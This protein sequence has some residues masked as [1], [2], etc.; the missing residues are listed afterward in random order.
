MTKIIRSRIHEVFSHEA[1]VEFELLARCRDISNGEKHGEINRLL[2]KYDVTYSKLGPGTNRYAVKIKGYVFKFATD[3]DGK[4]DNMKEFQMCPHLY[5]HVAMTYEISENGT[6][7]VA[8]Y[9]QPFQSFTEMC[10]YADEIR[11]I[12]S[13]LSSQYL[14]G[15]VGIDSKNYANW[16]L[17]IGTKDPVCL[18]FA[19]VYKV[20]SKLFICDKPNCSHNSILVPDTDF[21][22]L[23]CNTCK[24]IY[25]FEE[26]RSR[27]GN[28][29]VRHEIGNL[30]DTGYLMYSPSEE[31][32]LD[33]ER[34]PYI[35]NISD[36]D[37]IEGSNNNSE[38]EP[39]ML[40]RPID[41][42]E[43]PMPNTPMTVVVGVVDPRT[44]AHPSA[45]AIGDK[46]VQLVTTDRTH[47]DP[48]LNS[49][50]PVTLIKP[51][52]NGEQIETIYM[53]TQKG[54][55]KKPTTT[56]SAPIIDT[57]DDHV[58]DMDKINNIDVT[59]PKLHV[60]VERGI[61]PH[62]INTQVIAEPVKI[63]AEVSEPVDEVK[64]E[65]IPE[66]PADEM[67]SDIEEVA[68]ADE[69][70]PTV[71]DNGP[72][73]I[74]VRDYKFTKGFMSG[75]GAHLAVGRITDKIT[76][77]INM[78][79]L[80][81]EVSSHIKTKVF[82]GDFGTIVNKSLFNTITRFC[83]MTSTRELGDD[84]VHRTR[85]YLGDDVEDLKYKP[86]LIFM[87][88]AFNTAEIYQ[89][90]DRAL[91]NEFRKRYHNCCGLQPDALNGFGKVIKSKC[92][93]DDTGVQIITD[94]I[95]KK[96]GAPKDD[97]T[98]APQPQVAETEP[99]EVSIPEPI[100]E[101]K[102]PII[103]VDSIAHHMPIE[104]EIPQDPEEDDEE[105]E[106]IDDGEV[107]EQYASEDEVI[108]EMIQSLK[109]AQ[110]DDDDDSM[111]EISLADIMGDDIDD[112]QD[113]LAAALG[114]I[115]GDEHED[116]LWDMAGMIM[117]KMAQ[118]A[119]EYP[120]YVERAVMVVVQDVE[121]DI[122]PII[123]ITHFDQVKCALNTMTINPDYTSGEKG[124]NNARAPMFCTANNEWDWLNVV[125]PYRA[126]TTTA[127]H[128]TTLL[129][130][131]ND[132]CDYEDENGINY[133]MAVIDRL[134][135]G[136]IVMGLYPVSMSFVDIHDN[137]R[138]IEDEH[139][140]TW[141]KNKINMEIGTTSMSYRD[142]VLHDIES[143]INTTEEEIYQEFIYNDDSDDD[144]DDDDED[145]INMRSLV[146]KGY[147]NI[148]EGDDDQMEMNQEQVNSNTQNDVATMEEKEQAAIHALNHDTPD[149]AADT[150]LDAI[151]EDVDEVGDEREQEPEIAP[152]VPVE[153]NNDPIPVHHQ[154]SYEPE[155]DDLENLVIPRYRK[156]DRMRGMEM[157]R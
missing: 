142:R 121:P 33:E 147:E 20:S 145:P 30:A 15:D 12:L 71:E 82:K 79:Q 67:V 113:R 74:N 112:F 39:E 115:S 48:M 11:K 72:K 51:Q 99:E 149:V 111:I 131:F 114:C 26:I 5:P 85:W 1:C 55:P 95:M 128:V 140:I 69:P 154:V 107:D 133:R 35:S 57:A 13:D 139:E 58:V 56:I 24:A 86:T 98:E 63:P 125:E 37:N 94:L 155:D 153:R 8:E 32:E 78:E 27:L 9:V 14:I 123:S 134:D 31:F 4:I 120:K 65:E 29:P 61:H 10:H 141:L 25:T 43:T 23:K 96:W 19:Y 83:G 104:I 89:A 91:M 60:R 126:F 132:D 106:D 105:E 144:D 73:W 64:N 70:K 81:G 116:V 21:N 110:F 3:N 38:E 150:V 18:D 84:G 135:D 130:T 103:Q 129:H 53:P 137:E 148:N 41:V 136:R 156:K 152:K 151:A 87:D 76:G 102:P 6:M 77:S 101:N 138:P 68:P 124:S 2:E 157:E 118:Q 44:V 88:L 62:P 66:E 49:D 146:T 122:D 46:L 50:V 90:H 40:K 119:P 22:V 75:L 7:L 100:D 45:R 36:G 17:R 127:D 42:D 97:A 47:N 28:D 16:G 93:I 117:A 59:F 92:K 54:E 109:D 52:A 108:G 34:S 143:Y 80:F